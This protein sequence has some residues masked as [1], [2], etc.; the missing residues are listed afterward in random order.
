[1]IIVTGGSMGIGLTCA[2]YLVKEGAR[3]ILF[4]RGQE[5]LDYAAATLRSEVG[6][7]AVRALAGDVSVAG[8]I[9]HVMDAAEEWG[10]LDGVIHAAAVLGPIGAVVNAD[11][12]AWFDAVRVNLLGTFLVARASCQRMI[13]RGKGG[14]IVLFSGGGSATP[15]PNYTAYA[16]G[17]VGVV[18]FAET[19]AQEVAPYN[20]RVNCLAPGFVATR[21][22]QYTLAAG[23]AAGV[24]YLARTKAE[25]AKGGASPELAA[26]AAAFLLSQR[27][28]GIS[29]RLVAAQWDDWN[30]WPEHVDEIRDSDLFTLRRIVPH[31]RGKDWQ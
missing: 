20:I 7:A 1:M 29:G 4:A 13:R 21:M 2:R 28:A 27:A 11:P 16:C 26:R 12:E 23:E 18:R 22:H 31:D 9:E 19:L 3:V 14:S 8:A 10:G 30:Q 6:G 5:Q 25:L 24:S 15:F 17:K